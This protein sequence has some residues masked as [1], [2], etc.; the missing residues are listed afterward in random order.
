[1]LNSA[2]AH[3]L[4]L[5]E[6]EQW[7]LHVQLHPAQPCTQFCQTGTVISASFG[8]VSYGMHQGAYSVRPDAAAAVPAAGSLG[9]ILT[10]TIGSA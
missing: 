10:L 8:S 7:H 4:D 2:K 9:A 3:N 1:M 5:P 6:Y